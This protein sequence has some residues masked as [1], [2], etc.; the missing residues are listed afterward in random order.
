MSERKTRY[1]GIALDWPTI[2]AAH[3]TPAQYCLNLTQG[4]IISLISH[5]EFMRWQTRWVD[6][7]DQDTL[8]A[9]VDALELKLTGCGCFSCA[10]VAACITDD[11]G[12][13]AALDGYLENSKYVRE[14]NERLSLMASIG[15]AGTAGDG[16]DKDLL[17]GKITAMQDELY[18]SG[19]DWIQ[20]LDAS[21]QLTELITQWGDE[22]TALLVVAGTPAAAVAGIFTAVSSVVE[23]W[24]TD[25]QQQYEAGYTTELRDELRCEFFCRQSESCEFTIQD[26]TDWIGEELA[27]PVSGVLDLFNWFLDITAP[28]PRYSVLAMWFFELKLYEFGVKN[29][30]GNM[31]AGGAAQD[32]MMRLNRVILAADPDND[33]VVFCDCAFTWVNSSWTYVDLLTPYNA[34]DGWTFTSTKPLFNVS[35]FGG[36]GEYRGSSAALLST[37]TIELEFPL[38]SIGRLTLGAYGNGT[39]STY[40]RLIVKAYRDGVELYTQTSDIGFSA[41]NR[42][43]FDIG[44]N[45]DKIVI[46]AET[47]QLFSGIAVNHIQFS[48][49]PE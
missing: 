13:Q 49:F 3:N 19:L 45:V 5:L 42:Y 41:A 18:A 11:A 40:R 6:P 26:M 43:N 34:P 24:V 2:E 28:S 29:P 20:I 37:V 10:E 9:F 22:V 4:E 16:C 17:F 44:D 32:A 31:L 12:V 1:K 7:P 33:H 25:L 39:N 21:L 8:S 15:Y 38:S 47:L 46:V 35:Q 48:D 36:Y 14:L 30:I 23:Q 27:P